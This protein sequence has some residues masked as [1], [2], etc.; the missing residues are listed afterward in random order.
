MNKGGIQVRRYMREVLEEHRDQ[1]T[2]EVNM[3]AL[4]EDACA[5]V[6]GYEGDDVPERYFGWAYQVAE[7]DEHRRNHTMPLGLGHVTLWH[8]DCLRG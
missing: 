8:D 6:D 7:A 3:T 5:H 2:D 4:A 1:L